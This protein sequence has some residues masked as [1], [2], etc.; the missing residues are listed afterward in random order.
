MNIKNHFLVY[1]GL[2]KDIYFLFIAI[3]VNKLG[4]F[5]M[6]LLALILTVKIGLNKSEAGLFSTISMLSQAPF[7][8]LGGKLVD[9]FGSKKIIVIP[10]LLGAFIYLVCG[11]LKPGIIVVILIIIAS[12][13][14]ATAAPAYNSIVAEVTPSSLTKNAY[15]LTYLGINLGLAVGPA[16]GGLLFNSYLNL[17]FILDALTTVLAT[18]LIIFYVNDKKKIDR[19]LSENENEQSKHSNKSSIFSFLTKNPILVIFSAILLIYNFCYI[20]W[21]FLLP[22]QLE[23]VFKESGAKLFSLLVSINAVTVTVL[24]AIL[25]SVTQKTHPL[26]AIF[27]G[28]IFYFTSFIL[29]AINR[30]VLIFIIAI[31]VMTI[32]EILITINTNSY[33]AQRTPKSHI[34]RANSLLFI[35]SGIGYAVG[36]VVIGNALMMISYQIAWLVISALMFCSTIAM[37]A[38]KRMDKNKIKIDGY[39][40]S[41]Y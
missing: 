28:S 12:D 9:I 15:S 20:Q 27:W 33:I 1:K 18:S 30:F 19:S 34:G 7:I 17:L 26:K 38:I 35:E 3:V 8:M 21:N 23:D 10:A 22:L 5:I 14:Y 31:V 4:S 37:N 25:T 39:E 11:F 36:P 40:N 2:P 6:P 32:G 29:F 16:L 13:I 24:T 41:V